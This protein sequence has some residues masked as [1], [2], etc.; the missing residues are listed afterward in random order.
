MN[1][2]ALLDAAAQAELVRKKQVKPSELLDAAIERI[3]R[4]NPQIRFS[5]GP[6]RLLP[7]T[8]PG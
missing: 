4:L 8:R 5:R 7:Q 6:L 2:I 1:D 3:Q